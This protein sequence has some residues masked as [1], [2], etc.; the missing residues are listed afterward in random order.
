MDKSETLKAYTSRIGKPLLRNP[1]VNSRAE[2]TLLAGRKLRDQRLWDFPILPAAVVTY[3][4]LASSREWAISGK[5]R[6][7]ARAVDLINNSRSVELATGRV[8]YGFESFLQRRALDHIALGRTVFVKPTKQ[9]M[10]LEYLDASYLRME[11]DNANRLVMV[12]EDGRVFDLDELVFHHA[13]PVGTSNF[14][15][16][17][18]TLAPIAMLA[19]LV[20]EHDT[21]KLDGRKLRDIIFVAN[22]DMIESVEQAIQQMAALWSGADPSQVGGVPLVEINNP[23]GTP[24]ANYVYRLGLSEIPESFD[25][26]QFTDEYVNQI[27]GTLGLALRHFWNNEKTTNRALE[28]VQEARQQQK[29]PAMFVRTEQRLYNNRGIFDDVLP[30]GSVRFAF[31]EETDTNSQ[32]THARVLYNTVLA[33]EKIQ[34]VFG[35]SIDLEAYLAWMQSIHMLPNDLRLVTG[36]PQSDLH[37]SDLSL[38]QE[39]A[40]IQATTDLRPPITGLKY[41]EVMLDRDG[42]VLE[43]RL[44]TFKAVD[45]VKPHV[46][47]LPSDE[48]AFLESARTRANEIN[49]LILN[50]YLPS[51]R[52]KHP[53]L[54]A[55]LEQ[56]L[57][58]DDPQQAL[59][60][61]FYREVTNGEEDLSITDSQH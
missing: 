10:Y 29:G 39:D 32:L 6:A 42:R 41:D 36:N 50:T 25:R 9:R 26:K 19:W 54:A 17:L 56:N 33:M 47:Q 12:Y 8:D 18:Q 16:P 44:K 51:L 38:Y 15:A 58:I 31:I 45:L 28:E 4:E 7:V 57:P 5:P 49:L 34:K 14:I 24:L 48:E 2:S 52:A 22:A 53:D 3:I 43:R 55:L 21:A 37:T 1:G 20:R 35:A 60:D 27:A 23:S 13:V 30:N 11:Y 46:V 61:E 59:L 40:E